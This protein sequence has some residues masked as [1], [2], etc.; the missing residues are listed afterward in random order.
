MRVSFAAAHAPTRRINTPTNTC[1]TGTN[2]RCDDP[3]DLSPTN[4]AAPDVQSTYALNDVY[5][6]V[7]SSGAGSWNTL[8]DYQFSYQQNGPATHV[9]TATNEGIS[10]AGYFLLSKLAQVGDDGTTALPPR[11]FGY[12]PIK[13]NYYV[14]DVYHP[15]TGVGCGPAWNTGQ[16]SGC[17]L[18]IHNYNGNGYYL[19]TAD[20]GMGLQETFTWDMARNNTHGVNG[21]GSNN[22]DPL[23]CSH[24]NIT[25]Q[26]TYPCNETD[27]E[28]WSRFVLVSREGDVVRAAS[29]S[30][31][32]ISSVTSYAY[33]LTW[34]LPE[35]ACS[36]CVAGM[37]WGNQNDGDY[38]DYY[39]AFFMGFA[40]TD[41]G[42]PDGS[43]EVHKYLSTKGYGLYDA[44]VPC[45]AYVK[46]CHASPWWDLANAGH[47]HEV[48]TD[49]FD[50]DDT[51]LL[52]QVTSQYQLVCPPTGIS[53]SPSWSTTL[54][55]NPYTYTWDGKLVA[56]LDHGNPV[57][58]CDIQTA[59][60]DTYTWDGASAGTAVPHATTTYAY[61]AL[62][63]AT[64]TTTTSNDGGATGSP[65]PSSKRPTTSRTMP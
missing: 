33:K 21:G 51:T 52:K 8:T 30:S 17:L 37:Y 47:G 44:T 6:Q 45:L 63:R 22:A 41:V 26:S 49:Y 54:N 57:A 3:L 35:Q 13:Y 4:L 64:T 28:N 5:V 62:G 46:P 7:R 15:A 23:Y 10:T 29:G 53:G 42:N 12:T 9:D 2:L 18:W 34:P 38:L 20:N 60:V 65:T 39:N 27:D 11:T 59:Q 56:A 1:N 14:D 43:V 55:G 24:L 32:T 16:G 58:V 61:D 40:E 25:G 31:P 48:E 19:A 50:T 36:D